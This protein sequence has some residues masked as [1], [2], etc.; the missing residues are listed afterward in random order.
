MNETENPY[1]PVL[2]E[3]PVKNKHRLLG[4]WRISGFCP[5][6][7]LWNLL[8]EVFSPVQTE[9]A[10]QTATKQVE[11]GSK[12][13]TGHQPVQ[14]F[15]KRENTVES[16][17][18]V[19]LVAFNISHFCSPSIIWDLVCGVFKA[20]EKYVAKPHLKHT[21]CCD[22]FEAGS[23]EP[24][25]PSVSPTPDKIYE[26]EI[27]NLNQQPKNRTNMRE[28]QNVSRFSL[29][30]CAHIFR[31]AE[32]VDVCPDIF[33]KKSVV[34][35]KIK[36]GREKMHF[37]GSICVYVC[38]CSLYFPQN[39]FRMISNQ[40]DR[41]PKNKENWRF[42][43]GLIFPVLALGAAMYRIG[44]TIPEC[45]SVRE[46]CKYLATCIDTFEDFYAYSRDTRMGLVAVYKDVN[47]LPCSENMD[48]IRSTTCHSSVSKN[49]TL[50]SVYTIKDI[51]KHMADIFS[52]Q[53][54][55]N[56]DIDPEWCVDHT[57][58]QGVTPANNDRSDN[59]A[60]GDT[61]LV[62]ASGR[63]SDECNMHQL[64]S[65]YSMNNSLDYHDMVHRFYLENFIYTRP[66]MPSGR[67][68]LR[69][70]QTIFMGTNGMDKM[71]AQTNE[72]TDRLNPNS[73]YNWMLQGISSMI[74]RKMFLSTCSALK[75]GH[76][77]TSLV[78]II[79]LPGLLTMGIYSTA[80]PWGATMSKTGARKITLVIFL[81]W[82]AILICV[83]E[84]LQF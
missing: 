14:L 82:Q 64:T 18:K 19:I 43:P 54:Y 16:E 35:A 3:E 73:Y 13:E 63:V 39:R 55:K 68:V 78:S 56:I 47:S 49:E 74:L 71:Y 17:L 65:S 70:G 25:A 59:G 26:R 62:T 23:Q 11:I 48:L 20:D 38:L 76:I 10:T 67:L 69:W 75:W 77:T 8:S 29:L 2:N 21:V 37:I 60:H 34:K 24:P 79:W 6:R 44:D 66:A 81:S 41:T 31:T 28:L 4:T 45:F 40:T 7:V 27:F 5:P 30:N 1:R 9:N 53:L 15:S 58:Q 46:T 61:E 83:S 12:S 36:I 22:N 80:L 57:V 51:F 52:L 72:Q 32:L 50:R 84:W 42:N 33:S